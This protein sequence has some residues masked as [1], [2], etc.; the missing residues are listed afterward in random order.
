MRGLASGM[1]QEHMGLLIGGLLPAVFFGVAGVCQKWSNQ[2]GITTG[3]YLVSIGL[4]VVLVGAVLWALNTEQKFSTAAVIPAVGMGLSWGT[5]VVLVALGIS[6]YGS[7]ISQLAPLY[8]MNTLVTVVIAL[9][10]FSEWK[11]VHIV[12]LTIGALMIIAGG[13]LVSS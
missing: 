8:N 6:K 13:V 11:D 10:V 3:V 4:G 12:K 1:T 5:G 2:H 7:P 9:F